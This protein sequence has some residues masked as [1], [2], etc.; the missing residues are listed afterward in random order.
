MMLLSGKI[1]ATAALIGLSLGFFVRPLNE[2]GFE[3]LTIVFA[4]LSIL[5]L[6]VGVAALIVLIWSI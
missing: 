5:M 6:V 3:V 4:A 2:S 1:A